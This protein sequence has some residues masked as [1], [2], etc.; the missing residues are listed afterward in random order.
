MIKICYYTQIRDAP[1]LAIDLMAKRKGYCKFSV[2]PFHE[3]S[4]LW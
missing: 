2:T 4:N 3:K 1:I